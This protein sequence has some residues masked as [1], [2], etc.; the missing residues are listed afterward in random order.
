M[1]SAEGSKK[2]HNNIPAPLHFTC[3][4]N[5]S[6]GS[7]HS[8]VG[9]YII[10]LFHAGWTHL[11]DAR[12]VKWARTIFLS[13]WMD[14]FKGSMQSEGTSLSLAGW[15]HLK[16]KR[17]VNVACTSSSLAGCTHLKAASNRLRFPRGLVAMEPLE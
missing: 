12:T 10:A 4:M 16:D 2:F 15:T 1:T 14:I 6:K 13:W 11:K 3:W 17:T 8:E 9:P 7:K 5:T